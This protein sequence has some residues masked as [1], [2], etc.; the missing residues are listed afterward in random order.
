[1]HLA[2]TASIS[3]GMFLE[4]WIHVFAGTLSLLADGSGGRDGAAAALKEASSSSSSSRGG[5]DDVERLP[6]TRDRPAD[7]G[8]RGLSGLLEKTFLR[9]DSTPDDWERVLVPDGAAAVLPQR[10]GFAEGLSRQ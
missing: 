5:G 2:S 6:T 9:R 1:M 10:G 3:A 7:I 8:Q 4:A